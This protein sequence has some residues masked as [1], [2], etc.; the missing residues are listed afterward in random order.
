MDAKSKQQQV[1]TENTSIL[2]II[3][4][5][6]KSE[7]GA[8]KTLMRKEM[9]PQILCLIYLK[10]IS[11]TYLIGGS[12]DKTIKVWDIMRD[13]CLKTLS[14]HTQ[15]VNCLLQLKEVDIYQIISGSEDTTIKVWDLK[16]QEY[17]KC[18]KTLNFHSDAV[19]SITNFPD[20]DKNIIASG[21]SDKNIKIIN[22]VTGECNKTLTAHTGPVFCLLNLKQASGCLLSTGEDK[23]LRIWNIETEVCLKTKIGHTDIVLDLILVDNETLATCGLDTTIVL[24]RLNPF[25]IK[26]TLTSHTNTVRCLLSLND[27]YK[28]IMLSASEDLTVKTWNTI[29]NNGECISTLK[30]KELQLNCFAFLKDYGKHDIATGNTNG[31]IQLMKFK[32]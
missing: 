2:N 27:A 14:G 22:V 21:G 11:P 13:T 9:K 6:E 8:I 17:F 15:Q 29:S 12:T 20:Y 25:E 7:L 28:G 10:D 30:F 3:H 4:Y 1:V 23:S 19:N 24:W 16:S 18:V 31:T 32:N 26:K 5:L